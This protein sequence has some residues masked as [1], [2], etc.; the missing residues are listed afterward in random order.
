VP[1]ERGGEDD[2]PLLAT[3]PDDQLLADLAEIELGAV[4]ERDRDREH[5]AAV[6]G[7]DPL[8]ELG[9]HDPLRPL[10]VEQLGAEA[11]EHLGADD[12]LGEVAGEQQRDRREPLAD[13]L[14]L[15]A[16]TVPPG[17][18]VG[19]GELFGEDP[20]DDDGVGQVAVQVQVG[21]RPLRL[22]NGPRSGS[23]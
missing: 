4:G 8:G 3:R 6:L 22:A 9:V 7:A 16:L 10:T 17:A 18:E 21:E 11:V 13:G 20:V 14:E 15:L 1:G 2:S 19:V 5:R 23:S 12:L